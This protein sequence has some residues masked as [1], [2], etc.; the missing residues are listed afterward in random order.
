MIQFLDMNSQKIIDIITM[1][2]FK[3]KLNKVERYSCDDK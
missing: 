2:D 1:D 3:L